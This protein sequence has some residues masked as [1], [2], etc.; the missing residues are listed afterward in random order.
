MASRKKIGLILSGIGGAIYLLSGF[1]FYTVL[2][3][4]GIRFGSLPFIIT[5]VIS[6]VGTGIGVK[7]I[8]IGSIIILISIPLSFVIGFIVSPY[9]TRQY[10]IIL[11]F[12][13]PHI[14]FVIVGGI[15]CLKSA[16]PDIKQMKP[17]SV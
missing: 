15:L 5:G 4:F 6:L 9:I 10:L 8:K 3:Y 14:V 7:K 1:G 13:L 17:I 2:R 11:F 16:D 12:S